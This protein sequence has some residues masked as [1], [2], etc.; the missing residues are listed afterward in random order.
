MYPSNSDPNTKLHT[1]GIAGNMLKANW[2][3]QNDKSLLVSH[4]PG[5]IRCRLLVSSAD[6][7]STPDHYIRR[8]QSEVGRHHNIRQVGRPSRYPGSNCLY[9]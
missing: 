7:P 4:T 6:A 8:N 3:V 1:D 2:E 9:P 5:L